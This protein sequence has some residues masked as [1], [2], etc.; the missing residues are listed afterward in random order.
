[1]KVNGIHAAPALIIFVM[2]LTCAA[3]FADVGLEYM[4][5]EMVLAEGGT[6]EHSY[7][8]VHGIMSSWDRAIKDIRALESKGAFT[9][10]CYN[11]TFETALKSFVD[12]SAAIAEGCGVQIRYEFLG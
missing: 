7:M 4:I 3:G 2:A 5:D 1:M 10:D 11:V 12:G 9:A 8:P 6:A